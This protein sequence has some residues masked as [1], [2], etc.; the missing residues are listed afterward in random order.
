[1]VL[2]LGQ[3]PFLETQMNSHSPAKV[4]IGAK[5][6]DELK[7]FAIIAAYLYV[8]FT[9]LLFYKASILKAQA[10]PFA[11]F[12][13]AVA[14]ALI[15]AKFVSVGH[16]LHV[17]ERFKSLPLIWPTMYKSLAFL[18]LL[19]ALN[20]LEEVVVGLMHHR[21]IA[22]SLAEFG[23]GTVEQLI[24]TSIVGLLILVPFF[25]FRT[26]GEVVGERNL[27][28]VFFYHGRTIDNDNA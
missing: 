4:S 20:A 28:R 1:M 18:I 16:V 9:A 2:L 22:D 6:T 14:K 25:A 10:I 17:G 8:C 21:T 12:G 3:Y 5:V 24:A 7:E 15:C 27:V 26:L 13:F 19:L 11:P 23:G